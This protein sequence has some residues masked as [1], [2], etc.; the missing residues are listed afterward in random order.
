MNTKPP[1]WEVPFERNPRYVDQKI[2]NK[3][4]RKLFSGQLNRIAI[5]GLGGVGKTQ[6][7]L[8]L[9]YQVRELYSDCLVFWI[10]AVDRESLQQ[11]YQRVAEKLGINTSNPSGPDVKVLVQQHLSQSTSGRWLLIFD[12]ADNPDLWIESQDS[13]IERPNYFLPSSEQGTILFTTRSNKVARQLSSTEIFEIP[14]MDEAKATNVL[15]NN[16]TN[17]EL[18]VDAEST[19]RLLGRLTY[20]PLAIVQAAAFINENQ[21]TIKS[22]VKLLDGQEQ[23]AIDLLSEDF[24]DEGRYGS[25]RNPVATT[26]LTSFEQI[27]HRCPLA[28]QYLCFMGCMTGKDM[29][30]HLLPSGSCVEQEKAI[31]VLV[32]YSFVRIGGKDSIVNLHRLVH[33]AIRNWMRKQGVLTAWENATLGLLRERWPLS[34]QFHRSLERKSF[35][36]A[37]YILDHTSG[38]DLMWQR[39]C[40]L[41]YVGRGHLRDGRHREA[42]KALKEAVD[43]GELTGEFSKEVYAESIYSLA[44]TR[45]TEGNLGEAEVLYKKTLDLLT[46]IHG[47]NHRKVAEANSFIA[48][49][50]QLQGELQKAEDLSTK[51]IECCLE[52]WGPKDHLAL[53]ALN[54]LVVTYNEMGR[55]SD[56][57]DL[58]LQV[59]QIL[60]SKYEPDHLHVAGGMINL[61][62]TYRQLWRLKEAETLYMDALEIQLRIGGPEVTNTICTM[63][64]LAVIW[65]S[66][67]R[68]DQAIALMA[69][70]VRLFDQTC[71]PDDVHTIKAL[72]QLDEWS[73]SK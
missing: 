6:I 51:T 21:T 49:L 5:F 29:P 13:H 40:L 8:E 42:V 60:R 52:N 63:Y 7:A 35:P 10:P 37:L 73:S 48:T 68:R 41:S 23:D 32:S 12:N 25:I 67:G 46:K 33:L 47:P 69:E 70:C 61:A 11:A 24:E 4:K 30:L 15:H 43:I 44:V 64:S 28:H 38:E 50:Y 9:A 3:I 34:D 22:Y 55:L 66:R 65:A 59:L 17:K 27:S 16:L 20:L 2:T 71:G 72:S 31:G 56:A 53:S 62:E 19:R 36:H 14:E 58:A 57:K 39:Q 18:L 1:C 26:W 45:M 54:I